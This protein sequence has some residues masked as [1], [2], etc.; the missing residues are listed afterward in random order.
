MYAGGVVVVAERK[1]GIKKERK[2]KIAN[3]GIF[4]ICGESHICGEVH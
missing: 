1:E 2:I 3:R 4:D